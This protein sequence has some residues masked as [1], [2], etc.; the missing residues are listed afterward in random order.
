MD[1]K[2]FYAIAKMLQ[3]YFDGCKITGN[4]F[5]LKLWYD[6]L[7][8][9][10]RD[11]VIKSIKMLALESEFITIASIRKAC[12]KLTQGNKLTSADCLGIIN[13]AISKFGQ[14]RTVEA[15]EWIKQKDINTYHVVKA[16]G[17]VN[18]CKANKDFVRPHITK[19]YA[20]VS[21]DRENKK[22]LPRAFA[23]EIREIQNNG[24]KML[25]D[26]NGNI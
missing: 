21:Q 18:L 24:Y 23:R 12:L 5:K 26:K 1:K 16:I 15:V 22:L 20:E 17:F 19:M 9:L 7:Q 13:K 3:S 8:D 6:A 14:Y 2:E 10:D 4:E 25:S 11:I